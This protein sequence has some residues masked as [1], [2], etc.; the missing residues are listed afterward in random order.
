M[1]VGT[2]DTKMGHTRKMQPKET[3]VRVHEPL[4]AK[5][6]RRST[7]NHEEENIATAIQKK[8]KME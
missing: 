5:V 3:Q 6:V 8:K 7:G 1:L 2:T 4:V